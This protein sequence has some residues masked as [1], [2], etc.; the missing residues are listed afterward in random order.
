MRT[1]PLQQLDME[2][3]FASSCHASVD[4]LEQDGTDWLAAYAPDE[5]VEHV[6]KAR[7]G[8]IAARTCSEHASYPLLKAYTYMLVWGFWFD[9]AMVD[10]VAAS[11]PQHLPAITSVLDILDAAGGTGAAGHFMEVA[12]AEV[13]N[14]LSH[15]LTSSQ[16]QL[17]QSEMRLWFASMTLQNAMRSIGSAPSVPAYKTM[18]RYSVCT[19]PCIVIIDASWGQGVDI[20]TYWEPQM[21]RLRTRAANV[22]AWQNDIFSFYAEREHPGLFWNLPT[23]YQ[24]HGMTQEEAITQTAQDA[25]GEVEGFRQ[26]EQRH[27]PF[28]LAQ[29]RHVYSLKNWM[30][31]CHDWAREAAHRYIGWEPQP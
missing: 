31:G 14:E 20:Q 28:T 29:A 1:T 13:L 17:W 2:I 10:D 30:R 22:V 12:F 6:K 23:V 5:T 4:Q 18:R 19:M 11:S 9:D 8:R 27:R 21:S 15:V 25:R 24:A 3:P 26:D 7:A 16:Y